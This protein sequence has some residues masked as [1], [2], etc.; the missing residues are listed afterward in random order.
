MN[1]STK[2]SEL[3]TIKLKL[4]TKRFTKSSRIRSD[5]EKLKDPKIAEM[6]QAKVGGQFLALCVLDSD[7]DT[8]ANSLKETL[9]SAAEEVLS[10]QAVDST[11]SQKEV[12]DLCDQRRQLKQ[13]KYTSTE[14][15]PE[16][17]KVSRD[18]RKTMSAAREEW[19][20]DQCKNIEKGMM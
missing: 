18:V 20:E 10:R 14:A 1:L 3:T 12:W 5:L 19:I 4:K 9:L 16:Y 8:P 15:G 17:R 2:L 6:F 13:Q 11:L 7:V